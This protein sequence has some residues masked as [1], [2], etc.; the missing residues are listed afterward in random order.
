MS[1]AGARAAPLPERRV[2]VEPVPIPRVQWTYVAPDERDGKMK[3][4]RRLAVLGGLLAV[5]AMAPGSSEPPAR[6]AA[7][8]V[9]GLPAAPG[10][11]TALRRLPAGAAAEGWEIRSAVADSGIA[12]APWRLLYVL[13]HYTGSDDQP[14]RPPGFGHAAREHLL[15]PVAYSLEYAR[16]GMAFKDRVVHILR[17]PRAAPESRATRRLYCAVVPTPV[18]GRYRLRIGPRK[19]FI[20]HLFEVKRPPRL[21]WTPLL[22]RAGDEVD[23]DGRLVRRALQKAKKTEYILAPSFRPAAP[24]MPEA[25]V[26][27]AKPGEKDGHNARLYAASLPGRLP[28]L[29]G[30]SQWS[31]LGSCRLLM[32]GRALLRPDRLK[33][34]VRD[35]RTL[36]LGGLDARH[37][38]DRRLLARWWHNGRA[39]TRPLPPADAAKRVGGRLQAQA[40]RC[41]L[42]RDGGY[43]VD[44]PLVL[45]PWLAK[46]VKVG[47]TLGVQVLCCR[48]DWTVLRRPGTAIERLVRCLRKAGLRRMALSNRLDFRVTRAMLAPPASRPASAPAR[49]RP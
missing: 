3:G 39:V 9:E 8:V 17:N 22:G 21:C 30:W 46:R 41:E 36:R 37:D 16:P 38:L 11:L 48:D 5:G 45:P 26:W 27:H 7:K 1:G 25:A 18:A 33:A 14:P 31:G 28:A 44:V 20:E 43:T 35:G 49:A 6:P 10:S 15:G 12:G 34:T 2:F 23:K 47:D 19:G 29:R 13:I 32:H 4:L 40:V 24:G 42:R